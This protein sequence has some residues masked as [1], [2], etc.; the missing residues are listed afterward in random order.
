MPPKRKSAVA[1]KRG[2][3]TDQPKQEAVDKGRVS[4]DLQTGSRQDP[5]SCLNLDIVNLIFPSLSFPDLVCCE[6][7]SKS[8]RRTIYWWVAFCGFRVHLPHIIWDLQGRSE[9][10][11]WGAFKAHGKYLLFDQCAL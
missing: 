6:R 9:T 3:K 2:G 11:I 4:I 10:S 5:F 8:W 1:A 7:V